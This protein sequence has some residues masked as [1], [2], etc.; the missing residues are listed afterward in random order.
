M[1]TGWEKLDDQQLAE[2]AK[3]GSQPAF[4]EFLRRY[5]PAIYRLITNQIGDPDEALDLTQEAFVSGFAA[6]G[7]YDSSRPFRTWMTRIAINKCRDWA[8]R[9]KVRAFFTAALTL[10]MAQNVYSAEPSPHDVAQGQDEADRVRAAMQKLP[11][12]LREI[13]VLR[14]IEEMTQ[15]ESAALLK[16]SEKT[17]E[18][19][20][21]RARTRLRDALR[22]AED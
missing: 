20:L 12:N 19:R 8:R 6:I 22:M 3:S 15:S 7:R 18:T 21:Y 11:D 9:R 17:V 2:Y 5:K 14:A 16:V 13:L 4:R 10:D 1:S